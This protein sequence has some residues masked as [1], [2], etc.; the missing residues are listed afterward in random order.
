MT[1]GPTRVDRIGLFGALLLYTSAAALCL[2]G[3]VML[4]RAFLADAE[5]LL[6][7]ILCTVLCTPVG[8]ALWAYAGLERERNRRLDTVG[9]ASTAEVTDLTAWEDAEDAG[10]L[11]GLRISGPGFG[12]FETTW[13][14]SSDYGLRVGLRFEVVVDPVGSLYRVES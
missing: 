8:I 1:P 13:K 2:C 7:G 4:V 6:G 9:V 12:T 10:V 5:L 3:P 11:V 14:R